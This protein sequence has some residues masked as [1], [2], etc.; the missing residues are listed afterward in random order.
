MLLH[1][2]MC[3]VFLIFT[4]V[5]LLV[6]WKHPVFTQ[7]VKI[8]RWITC[9]M[10]HVNVSYIISLFRGKNI[11]VKVRDILPLIKYDSYQL[12]DWSRL[13]Q[14]RGIL[15]RQGT[16]SVIW[17][18]YLAGF[19]DPF[20]SAS[21]GWSI[22]PQQLFFVEMPWTL[23]RHTANTAL[24]SATLNHWLRIDALGVESDLLKNTANAP[25]TSVFGQW[26]WG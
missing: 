6:V 4:S 23:A 20:E 25:T 12:A 18:C 19:F 11:S 5:C 24:L 26:A 10:S 13:K 7:H 1:W 8:A 16:L 17:R 21:G 15:L 9:H 14:Q 22:T 3:C 2:F